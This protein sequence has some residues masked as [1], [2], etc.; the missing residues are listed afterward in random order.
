M[1][2]EEKYLGKKPNVSS[3]AFVHISKEHSK[4]MDEKSQK[5]LFVGYNHECKVYLD[6]MNPRD[7]KYIE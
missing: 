3:L 6:C 1:T 2:P 4:R 5:C 7:E